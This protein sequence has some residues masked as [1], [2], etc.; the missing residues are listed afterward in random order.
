M[1]WRNHIEISRKFLLLKRKC[2]GNTQW[3]GLSD[4]E[5][6]DV[7]WALETSQSHTFLGAYVSVCPIWNTYA[8]RYYC[9]WL[10]SY[11]YLNRWMSHVGH[12]ELVTASESVT[13]ISP[14]PLYSSHNAFLP[15]GSMTCHGCSCPELF[16]FHGLPRTTIERFAAPSHLWQRSV[17]LLTGVFQ[18]STI[19]CL[20]WYS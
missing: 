8:C 9:D 7:G 20:H 17:S 13:F 14:Q 12:P 6:G 5:E 3:K 2:W 11:K 1:E 4:H 16:P 10:G 18:G 19:P 15:L